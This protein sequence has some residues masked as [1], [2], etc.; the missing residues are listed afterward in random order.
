MRSWIVTAGL[1]MVPTLALADA[2][3]LEKGTAK[4]RHVGDQAAVPQRYRLDEH[5][6]AW[7]LEPKL[8]LESTG[9]RVFHVR[10][11]SPVVS[12]TPENNT[13][14]AEFYRP[15][16][17]GPFPG[18]IVLDVTGGDQQLSRLISTHLANKGV[19]ALFVQMAY[20]GPRRPAGSDL[21]MLSADVPRTFAALTQTVLDVRRASAWLEN[22][23][24]VDPKHLGI[25]GTSLGSFVAA[26][27]AESEPRLGKAAVMLGGGGFVEGYY[28]D[29]RAAPVRKVWEALGGT[30]ERMK[31][32]LAPYDPLTCAANL[33]DRKLLIIAAKRDD[34]VPP[35]CA[36]RLWEATGKQK[37]VW[38][39]C[40]HYGAALY[41][42]PALGHIT[43]HF[44]GE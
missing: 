1:M 7:E 23:P 27:A 37:I 2:P 30:R 29:P 44:R 13:V 10:F 16:G 41:M 9:V 35:S 43:T 20:Y 3:A 5:T 36:E 42:I 32:L 8:E 38:Y 18:V 33:K 40:T 25:I 26:L 6:F 14:H 21:R 19:A 12:P 24:D 34:I 15:K 39:N 11:P 22:R 28:D 31:E 17:A 4:F